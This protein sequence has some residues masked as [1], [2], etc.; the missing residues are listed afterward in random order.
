MP[1]WKEILDEIQKTRLSSEQQGREAHDA[2]RRR[3]LSAVHERT[4]RNVIAYYSGWLS[5]PD[6]AGAE[7]NH[8]DLNG[9]MATIHQLDRSKGLDLILHT[10]GGGM[11]AAMAIVNYL[12]M[13]FGRDIRAIVPQIAMSAGTMI[14]CSAKQILMAKHSQLGPTDPQLRGIAAAGVKSEFE[15]A[16]A[17]VKQDPTR[18]PV[19]QAIIGR[20][21]P[22][23]LSQCEQAVTQSRG[24]VEAQLLDNMFADAPKRRTLAR[25]IAKRLN[26]FS[27]N[28]SHDQPFFIDDCRK[29]GLRVESI[30]D[31]GQLQD[32]VLSAHHCYMHAFMNGPSFKVIENHHGVAIVKT[33][34][35]RIP[36]LPVAP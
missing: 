5:K 26:D 12:H 10:P 6:V 17:E 15:R 30:E 28:K 8:E 9:F 23:F 11:S 2:I 22:T 4:G 33:L 31:D 25:S 20:Y 19:W 3:Y 7:I 24:F 18:I 36:T 13:M 29:M 14:A 35:Q 21:S 1:N 16:C 32:A 27:K 34:V